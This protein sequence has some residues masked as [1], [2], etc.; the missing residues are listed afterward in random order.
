M[1]NSGIILSAALELMNDVFGRT[2]E[3]EK[4]DRAR[5]VFGMKSKS[6]KSPGTYD[7]DLA[8]CYEQVTKIVTRDRA[9]K[10][11]RSGGR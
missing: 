1:M 8:S 3:L 2:S 6:A 10:K 4:F 7:S 9:R 11:D 5:V